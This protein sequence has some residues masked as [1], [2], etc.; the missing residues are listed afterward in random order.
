MISAGIR[1]Y[2]CLPTFYVSLPGSLS[3][4][5]IGAALSNLRIATA[6]VY[7]NL[8]LCFVLFLLRGSGGGGHHILT[9]W[10]YVAVEAGVIITHVNE[11]RLS[12]LD[13]AIM[14][15]PFPRN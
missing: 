7:H 12:H 10:M 15:D 8:I 4:G 3:D 1:L 9:G 11:V 13:K 14:S 6:G 2:L 5:S